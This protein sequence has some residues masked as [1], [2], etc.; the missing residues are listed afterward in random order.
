VEVT[1]PPLATVS[2]PGTAAASYL[3][4]ISPTNADRTNVGGTA[5]L[6]GTVQAA[7]AAGSYVTRSYT[8]LSAAGGR[9]GTFN[10]LTTTNLPAGFTASLSYTARST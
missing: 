4:E 9:S 10:A 1:V 2:M 8:I 6:A 3:V 5:T 7:L